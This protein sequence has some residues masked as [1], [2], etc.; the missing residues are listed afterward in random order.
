MLKALILVSSLLI[1]VYTDICVPKDEVMNV[2]DKGY[3]ILEIFKTEYYNTTA[4]K[5]DILR[6]ENNG[7]VVKKRYSL[8][9][10]SGEGKPVIN[11]S[12][13]IFALNTDENVTLNGTGKEE[14]IANAKREAKWMKYF[15]SNEAHAPRFYGCFYD[16]SYYYII[17]ELLEVSLLNKSFMLFF[18]NIPIYNR[19]EIMLEMARAV[20]T[21]HNTSLQET[22]EIHGADVDE[23][24]DLLITHNNLRLKNF[25]FSTSKPQH[26]KILDMGLVGVSSPT[27]TQHMLKSAKADQQQPSNPL[28]NE[29]W[30]LGIAFSGLIILSESW[31]TKVNDHFKDN[32]IN[33]S[34]IRSYVDE[35]SNQ[36]DLVYPKTK[37]YQKIELNALKAV[38]E[39]ITD[40]MLSFD[41]SKVP[42]IGDIIGKLEDILRNLNAKSLYLPGNNENPRGSQKYLYDVIKAY[43][44]EKKNEIKAFYPQVKGKFSKKPQSGAKI[45]KRPAWNDNVVLPGDKRRRWL[46]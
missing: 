21:V 22:K 34:L 39:F 5:N 13:K 11:V 10:K 26:I 24:D 8:S 32:N 2:V 31:N 29:M 27:S 36:F 41:M 35:F 4:G 3:G 45:A 40:T 37:K 9:S 25:V 42:A 38:K 17:S 44:I 20:A 16:D 14:R 19:I 28:K 15:S 33:R 18:E 1:N 46:I 23:P 7:Y 12:V 43:M 30:R 6:K